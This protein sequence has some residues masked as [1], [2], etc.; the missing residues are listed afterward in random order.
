MLLFA[1]RMEMGIVSLKAKLFFNK[2]CHALVRALLHSRLHKVLHVS[3]ALMSLELSGWKGQLHGAQKQ[4]TMN[5]FVSHAS[6]LLFQNLETPS[7]SKQMKREQMPCVAM[8]V[9]RRPEQH[10]VL[11]DTAS[12]I[13]VQLQMQKVCVCSLVNG[14]HFILLKVVAQTLA[15]PPARGM[16]QQLHHST[17]RWLC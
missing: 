13:L 8:H 7:L 17:G 15:K 16:M 3:A 2:T 11:L 6:V 14:S 12:A 9:C 1:R 4:Y 5:T 10:A